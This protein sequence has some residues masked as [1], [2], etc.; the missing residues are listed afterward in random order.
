MLV[1]GDR[2]GYSPRER[3]WPRA[4]QRL[5]P[6]SGSVQQAVSPGPRPWRKG[7]L[8]SGQHKGAAP[9]QVP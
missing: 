3:C 2:A 1:H 9:H 7:L 4:G 8:F 6:S 5:D